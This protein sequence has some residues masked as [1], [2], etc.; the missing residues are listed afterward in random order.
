MPDY[1]KGIVSVRLRHPREDR[2]LEVRI[3]TT[4]VAVDAVFIT[5]DAVNKILMP[6]YQA[7]PA[8]ADDLRRR[9]EEQQRDGTCLVIHQ[10]SCKSFVPPIDWNAKSPI[11]L[12]PSDWRPSDASSR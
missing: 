9:V 3:N 8:E 7:K 6:V 10:Y 12:G 5:V 1:D 11:N 2:E 4:D